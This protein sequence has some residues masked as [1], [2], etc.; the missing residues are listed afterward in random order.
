M[1]A[2]VRV[3]ED[4][5]GRCRHWHPSAAEPYAGTVPAFRVGE[6]DSQVIDLKEKI[7]FPPRS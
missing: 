2:V 5:S 4:L 7:P 6:V 1:D 3:W